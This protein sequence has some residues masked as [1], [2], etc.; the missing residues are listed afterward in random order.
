MPSPLDIANWPRRD[1]FAYF[2]GF[3]KPYF[4]ICTKLDEAPLQAAQ[5][6]SGQRRLSLAYHFIAP[7]LANRIECFRYR[8]AG[9]Q[10][11][12]HDVVHGSTTV[13]R[14][15]GSFG[16]TYLELHADFAGFAA[17]AAA[18]ITAAR[19]A[20]PPFEPRLDDSALLHFT[21]LTWLHFTS[22]S[23]A[24]NWGREDSV[25]KLS[26]GPIDRDGQRAW[27]P[28]SVE[29]H[30]ALMDGLHVGQYVQAFEAALLAPQAWLGAATP[31]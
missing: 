5:A 2:R 6:E 15:D 29:L 25:P 10:V 17:P 16:F 24:R 30:H 27:M 9:A 1:A 12:V 26:S 23:H 8:L 20:N 13:L 14:D 19:T 4:N 28:F 21:T 3:D 18:A 31:P 7:S 11:L 22:F